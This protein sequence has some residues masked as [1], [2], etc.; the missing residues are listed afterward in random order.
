MSK[1]PLSHYI[2]AH[3]SVIYITIIPI[4]LTSALAWC[5][6][7]IAGEHIL[8][9]L[10]NFKMTLPKEW[11]MPL[12]WSL[13]FIP[14]LIIL[15]GLVF[16]LAWKSR[17]IPFKMHLKRSFKPTDVWYENEHRE[18][19]LVDATKESPILAFKRGG[20]YANRSST[21]V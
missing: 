11:G 12:G 8:Q 14:I 18:L 16:H 5:L 3:L 13:A 9:P 4:C 21:E 10:K 19:M 20:A 1:L 17:G 2:N 7:G 6:Y 15:G